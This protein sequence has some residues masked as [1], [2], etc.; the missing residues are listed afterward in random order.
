MKALAD[1]LLNIS[2]FDEI[3]FFLSYA[4]KNIH[5]FFHSLF[6]TFK[7]SHM[8]E[9][10]SQ[11]HQH[12]TYE[13]FVRTLFWQLFLV[14]YTQQKLLKR[15]LNVK[16]LMKL[17]TIGYNG[18]GYYLTSGAFTM[19]KNSTTVS[20]SNKAKGILIP[21]FRRNGHDI[22]IDVSIFTATENRNNFEMKNT[23]VQPLL[24]QKSSTLNK[25]IDCKFCTLYTSRLS[26]ACSNSK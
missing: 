4:R 8:I 10:C 23:I 5:A 16:M 21:V 19:L 9:S 18:C 12:F 14:A 7:N 26:N 13:F 11:F 20:C 2:F 24:A 1:F 15:C 22:Q 3:L 25:Q 17:G 6:K